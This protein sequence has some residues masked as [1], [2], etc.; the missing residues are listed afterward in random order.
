MLQI[1]QKN[2]LRTQS[3][4][5]FETGHGSK[6]GLGAVGLQNKS[7]DSYTSKRGIFA[8]CTRL[9][10]LQHGGFCANLQLSGHVVNPCLKLCV[11]RS[12]AFLETFRIGFSRFSEEKDIIFGH[13][14][15][16]GAPF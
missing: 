9:G 5:C 11:S 8:D 4:A 3:L 2:M 14:G 15:S 13:V 6:K 12:V 7:T 1:V 10:C 16:P